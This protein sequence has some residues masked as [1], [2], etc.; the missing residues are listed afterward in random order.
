MVLNKALCGDMALPLIAWSGESRKPIT[1]PPPPPFFLGLKHLTCIT[2]YRLLPGLD[3][4]VI[5]FAEM[6]P[7]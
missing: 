6:L 1:P 7:Q 5:Q 3:S 4:T 2:K